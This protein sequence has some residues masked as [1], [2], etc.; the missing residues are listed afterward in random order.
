LV[1]EKKEELIF[2]NQSPFKAILVF[3]GKA[4]KRNK[5]NHGGQRFFFRFQQT[6]F[7]CFS[8]QIVCQD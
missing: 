6:G 7:F 3:S 8:Q 1:F 4:K 5:R 2:Q